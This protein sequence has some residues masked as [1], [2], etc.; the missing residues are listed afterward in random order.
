MW[1]II[2]SLRAVWGIEREGLRLPKV[3]AVP[4]KS[5]GSSSGG[6]MGRLDLSQLMG[7]VGGGNGVGRI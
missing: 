7:G 1:C 2:N 6:L 3:G 4:S 5:V